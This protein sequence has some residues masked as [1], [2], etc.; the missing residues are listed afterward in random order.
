MVDFMNPSE[1]LLAGLEA[2]RNEIYPQLDEAIQRA[3]QAEQERDELKSNIMTCGRCNEKFIRKPLM[4]VSKCPYCERDKL[5]AIVDKLPKTKDGVPVVCGNFY[6][7]KRQDDGS[8]DET[9]IMVTGIVDY[10][11]CGAGPEGEKG[12]YTPMDDCVEG[13]DG[14]TDFSQLYSTKAAAEAAKEGEGQP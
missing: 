5:Q 3:E 10:Q 12:Y 13:C 6:Y 8:D 7:D 2:G 9:N 14:T 1:D 11:A 4:S